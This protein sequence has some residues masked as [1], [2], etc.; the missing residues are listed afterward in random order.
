MTANPDKETLVKFLGN[1]SGQDF[2]LAELI[3]ENHQLTHTGIELH[4]EVFNI[5]RDIFN[6]FI[7]QN[8]SFLIRHGILN[9][10]VNIS[11]LINDSRH[12]QGAEA[13]E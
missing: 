6:S 10:R 5:I 3:H 1:V 9:C 7:N 4:I 13:H 8:I 2:I 12:A 11:V